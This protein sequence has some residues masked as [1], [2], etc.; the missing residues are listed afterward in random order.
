MQ[1]LRRKSALREL[2]GVDTGSSSVKVVQ[3][4]KKKNR[5]ELA[6]AGFVDLKPDA[7]VG[8]EIAD[9][10]AVSSAIT[11]VFDDN[12]VTASE[13]ATSVAGN[14]VMVKRIVVA[15]SSP[16][17]LAEAVLA[18]AKRQVS[19]DLAEL[20]LD[21]QVLGPSTAPNS[22]DVMLVAARREKVSSRVNVVKQAGRN[23]VVVDL[24]AFAVQT[25]FE[26]A[27]QP[28]ADQTVALLNLGASLINVNIVRNGIPLFTR[29]IAAGGK[30]YT[31]A[32]Q[33]ALNIG[34]SE[35]EKFKQSAEPGERAAAAVQAATQ[36][37]VETLGREVEK[38]F[39]FFRQ[40]TGAGSIDRAYLSG[41]TARV[42]GLCER[43]QAEL[44][45]PVEVLDP[46]RGIAV[47]SS[48]FD[49]KQLAEL[50]PRMAVA[51]GL[52]LRSFDTP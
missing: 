19:A 9:A 39:N 8:G 5:L 46:L 2:A 43:L 10:P 24:D 40:M 47:S 16:E 21:Y 26:T 27:Y 31:A 32:L 52:A 14:A 36:E 30:Q 50:S 29:D 3:L 34:F 20:S 42:A 18:E 33:K 12:Q 25:A 17:Q 28:A 6:A 41:G 15:A 7:V 1:F 37:F 22:Q 23:P 44:K 45:I 51:V 35:A 11:Q 48:N 38:T 49:T 4:R 13:V